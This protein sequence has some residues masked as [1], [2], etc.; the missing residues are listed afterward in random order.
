MMDTQ[1]ASFGLWL[2]QRRKM[3]NLTQKG[4]ADCVGC[5]AKTI[6][7]IESGERR[8]SQQIA[9]LLLRCLQ[10]PDENW[11]ELLAYARREVAP[12][13]RGDPGASWRPM[14]GSLHPAGA[15]NNLPAPLTSFVGREEA[16]RA[17]CSLLRSSGARLVTL[18]GAPG[19]GKT[20]LALRVGQSLLPYFRD[21]VFFVAL[22]SVQEASLVASSIAA[23]LGVR[24]SGGLTLVES[25]KAYMADKELLL[26]LDNFEQVVQAAPLVTELLAAAA[27]LTVLATSRES[28]N[29][30]G[31]HNYAVPPLQV[32]GSEYRVSNDAKLHPDTSDASDAF[33]YEA[34]RL[35]IE[36]ATAAKHGFALA[37]QD[38]KAVV[39]ICKELD[40]L[41]LAI[42]LAAARV[43]NL[44]VHD[45]LPR[46]RDKLELLSAGPRDLPARQRTLRGAIE[47]SHDLLSEGEKRLFQRL[48]VFV[49]GFTPHAAHSV[50]GAEDADENAVWL[51]LPALREKSMLEQEQT[52]EG[53]QRF[54]MLETIRE[55]A[56]EQLGES[57]EQSA[58]QD[59]HALYYLELA[60]EAEPMLN[61]PD[62]ALWLDQLSEEHGNL[63]AAL[64]HLVHH[65]AE[66]AL[67]LGVGIA[68]FWYRRGHL[69]EGR[70]SL[71]LA[72]RIGGN[73]PI[74]L[75]AKALNRAGVLAYAQ[76]DYE[77]ARSLYTQ[78]LAAHRAT[79]D[80]REI[81]RVLNNL[82]LIASNQGDYSAARDLYDESM[83]LWR[84]LGDAAGIALSL[85]NIMALDLAR[86][87][88]ERARSAAEQSVE[89]RKEMGD[90]AG[91]ASSLG[92]LAIV[93][94]AL[95]EAER[96]T[97]LQ[98]E[99]LAIREKL[100]DRH[101]I[102]NCLLNLG[103][104]ARDRGDYAEAE[105][106][107]N[108][109]LGICRE[110]G[111]KPGICNALI[112]LGHL[113]HGRGEIDTAR[114]YFRESV[115]TLQEAGDRRSFTQS[116][117]GMAAVATSTGQPERAA[118]LLGA[119]EAILDDI[120]SQLYPYE[121]R[122]YERTMA[123]AQSLLSDADW[124]RARQNGR[125]MRL[126]DAC[127]YA[128]E[129]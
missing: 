26:V 21:G 75:R 99:S 73:V 10:V 122:D 104:L 7:K 41:P 111:D 105:R 123:A 69:S 66:A 12:G 84:E 27:N 53:S 127:R 52:A 114:G 96:A 71:L 19:I 116:L 81:A 14:P 18:T 63:R 119:V 89:L 55:Y 44:S 23:A 20:R 3:L 24:E 17:V 42:E 16:V 87:D 5:S 28:L 94:F 4:L 39:A 103:E 31:E 8:P 65:D 38:V 46:L 98:E 108:N 33:E 61:G 60:K 15:P 77:D 56:W 95:G 101:G 29:L 91:I 9:E 107:C 121:R 109:C 34:V 67:Q 13:A 22:A 51:E 6:E 90:E 117:V 120:G 70:L 37:G 124:Q 106:L 129:V 2:K 47:W 92:N 36:R 79:G 88:Y 93:L 62:Q 48:S 125:Q 32:P 110:L 68:M 97:R 74:E 40:G 43:T 80:K 64:S 100:G 45:L 86:G 118:R 112:N 30:Y 25:L 128:L 113:A 58:V 54:R 83:T 35:F 126:N 82:G 11:P 49:G 72:L 115:S 50:C 76:G 57:G 1:R 78:S 85:N 102:A 59:R